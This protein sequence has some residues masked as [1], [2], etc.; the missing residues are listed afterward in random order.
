MQTRKR[1][2]NAHVF[3]AIWYAK[4]LDYLIC[5]NEL[6]GYLISRTEYLGG[7]TKELTEEAFLHIIQLPNAGGYA[8][9]QLLIDVWVCTQLLQT[10]L[11]LYVDGS[12]KQV[13]YRVFPNKCV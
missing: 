5:R 8:G 7:A 3:Q 4:L 12:Q 13:D 11:A 9:G 1:F 6:L 10:R 2:G